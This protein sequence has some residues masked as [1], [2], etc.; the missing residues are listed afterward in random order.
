MSE[1]NI[2]LSYEEAFNKMESIL[3]KLEEGNTKLD[4]SL[5]LYEEGISL[6]RYCSK[7]IE[8][9]ELKITKINEDFEKAE[10]SS[11]DI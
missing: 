9:S 1:K 10:V 4:E 11:N 8:E 5:S 7:I 6:Y 3:K 2:E